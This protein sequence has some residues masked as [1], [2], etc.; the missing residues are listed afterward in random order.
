M[1]KNIF[2]LSCMGSR[3]RYN[4]PVALRQMGRLNKFFTDIYIPNRVSRIAEKLPFIPSP[5]KALLN[6]N[7][8]ELTTDFVEQWPLLGV[9][10]RSKIRSCNSRVSRQDL[11]LHY[12]SL[13]SEKVSKRISRNES[14]ISFTGQGLESLRICR[15]F[16]NLAVLD[17]VDP[18]LPEWQLVYQEEINNKDWCVSS[19]QNWSKNFEKRILQ[20]LNTASLVIVNSEYSKRC[21]KEWSGIKNVKVLDIPSTLPLVRRNFFNFEKELK[22]LYV[23]S[24]SIRK[25][26]QYLLPAIH[27]LRE[28]GWA[29]SLTLVG[30][31]QLNIDKMNEY[32]GWVYKGA[33]SKTDVQLMF[34][35]HDLFVFPT[36]SDGFGMVQV[37]AMSR[38]LPVIASKHCAE[39]VTNNVDGLILSE[40]STGAIAASIETYLKDRDLLKNHSEN[41]Y[42]KI[43]KFD[44]DN[45]KNRLLSMLEGEL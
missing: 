44:S 40:I 38:G 6:R 25:G 33:L 14:L 7:H 3:E 9:E 16:G 39:V 43:S 8:E 5:V 37:E 45:Y 24:I 34:D 12:G 26:I 29:V 32:E 4:M 23:G 42:L 21:I 22:I 27:Q 17:Q 19:I 41:T 35:K 13:F 28:R 1:T 36:L 18:G 31:L 20:E 15:E 11:L 30:E 10:F 2:S